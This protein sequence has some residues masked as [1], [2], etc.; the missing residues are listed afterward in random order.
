MAAKW[1][2]PAQ[3]HR[4]PPVAGN[5]FM[6][7]VFISY[8]WDS[9][10]HKDRVRA[11]ATFLRKN[12]IDAHLDQWEE[13][14]PPDG[15]PAWCSRQ[16]LKADV[17]VVIC[18]KR[19]HER[20]HGLESRRPGGVIWESQ[21]IQNLAY[22]HY[23]RAGFLPVILNDTDG[24]YVP[25]CVLGAVVPPLVWPTDG[26]WS[27]SG[28]LDRLNSGGGSTARQPLPMPET[29]KLAGVAVDQ[30]PSVI[31]E[32]VWEGI[33]R[34]QQR[35]E[36]LAD[37][38]QQPYRPRGLTR[39]AKRSSESSD[40]S[41]QDLRYSE[42]WLDYQATPELNSL[43]R[44]IADSA[45]FSWWAVIAPGGTGKSRLA[46]ELI[47]SLDEKAWDAAFLADSHWL[48]DRCRGWRPRRATLLVIDYAST[49]QDEVL[50]GLQTLTDTLKADCG[51][52]K[53]RMLLL[54]RSTGFTPGFATPQTALADWNT[55]RK[56]VRTT[57]FLPTVKAP[58]APSR[59]NTPVPPLVEREELIELGNPFPAQWPRIIDTAM[60]KVLGPDTEPRELPPLS[61]TAWWDNI[62]RLTADGRILY[63]E[64]LAVTLAREPDFIGGL[65][66]ASTRETI[67]D[68]IIDHERTTRWPAAWPMDR[69]GPQRA[70]SN[71]SF[72]AVVH[73]I[74]FATLVRGI[75][76]ATA[77]DWEPVTQATGLPEECQVL[78][79]GY[80]RVET[81]P[82]PTRSNTFSRF[83][84]VIQP[85][86]PDLLGERLLLRLSIPTGIGMSA[87]PAEISPATWI[88]PAMSCD[89]VGT[90]Q[91]LTLITED[92]SDH[93]AA[94]IWVS[95]AAKFLAS[96]SR[97]AREDIRTLATISRLGI[98]A[99]QLA[100]RNLLAVE[101]LEDLLSVAARSEQARAA[102][103]E[104]VVRLAPRACR[105]HAEQ[106]DE[107]AYRLAWESDLNCSA[108]ARAAV[109]IIAAY[110]KADR[111]SDLERWGL[112]LRLSADRY[113]QNRDLALSLTEA[114][115]NAVAAY[116]TAERFD[117][118]ER[119]ANTGCGVATNLNY[120]SDR[121]IQHAWL[122]SI[123]NI[124]TDYGTSERFV[125]LEHW[126]NFLRD[127]A[128][129][130]PHDR[131]I[132]VLVA[133]ASV[134]T[135]KAYG[136]RGRDSGVR[137][138]ADVLRVARNHHPNDKDI[139]L[140]FVR[141]IANV[142]GALREAENPHIIADWM[143]QLFSVSSRNSENSDFQLEAFKGAF[144]TVAAFGISGYPKAMHRW[145]AV[146][147]KALARSGMTSELM[148]G[149]IGLVFRLADKS[150]DVAATMLCILA[151][152]WPGFRI[153][154]PNEQHTRICFLPIV[155]ERKTSAYR[156]RLDEVA[157][158]FS[159][160]TDEYAASGTDSTQRLRK[161]WTLRM[162]L[163]DRGDSIIPM[164]EQCQLDDLV[165][166]A[167]RDPWRS[168]GAST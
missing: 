124:I 18:T 39:P 50:E 95:V 143:Q 33:A 37:Q 166:E 101:L 13:G 160:L 132:Q 115:V 91:T 106:W 10:E 127:E 162:Y 139:Q 130:N 100:I 60:R 140:A 51:F 26:D 131:D 4:K 167:A 133:Q 146:A 102:M 42:R 78:L 64:L 84:D 108:G 157:R 153:H 152:Y 22:F 94:S 67:L 2:F 28:I 5:D 142:I 141:G 83:L 120:S 145:A 54:D 103:I 155:T 38:I 48:G 68:T 47:D 12:G 80:L 73:S 137:R 31:D 63:L 149:G 16:I 151:D 19:Y 24:E 11:L 164:L 25:A 65:T 86:E 92:F 148:Y 77:A 112:A 150:P 21:T 156:D 72:K 105:D 59:I 159:L 81:H 8:S 55:I 154:L 66:D 168:P 49:K 9:D 126:A 27:G 53:V 114:C 3:A 71:P 17:I 62:A 58:V 75:P 96:E 136:N 110:G 138:W 158:L 32:S 6:P 7:R 117:D 76:I 163:P 87:R 98:A 147:S 15:W 56:Q 90:A 89:P 46:L 43:Q 57:L 36:I 41:L 121:D 29:K 144:H 125:E 97:P 35:I 161:L 135:I 109:K 128:K 116:G 14:T 79:R 74:A 107:L 165:A 99:T 93:P 69:G 52:P 123:F 111:F 118:L 88:A 82:V 119:W 129:R 134:N 122:K 40:P 20:F 85:L 23:L 34:I 1:R 30:E 45:P 61:D 113:H 104:G 70:L 44:W